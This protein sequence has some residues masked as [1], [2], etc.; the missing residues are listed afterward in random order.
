MPAASLGTTENYVVGY[1]GRAGINSGSVAATA[2]GRTLF[3]TIITTNGGGG[4]THGTGV[5]GTG[6]SSTGGDIN[7]TGSDGIQ[8]YT[9]STSSAHLEVTPGIG[10][11]TKFGMAGYGCGANGIHVD[12]AGSDGLVGKNGI[13]IL[14]EYFN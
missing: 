14:T 11:I 4:S 8:A 1:G 2:G 7:L 10:G 6:G 3:G 12:N 9:G 13:I 5:P